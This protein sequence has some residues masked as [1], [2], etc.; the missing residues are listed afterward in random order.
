MR[1]K[2]V[3]F[4]SISMPQPGEREVKTPAE[5]EEKVLEAIPTP[6]KMKALSTIRAKMDTW[7]TN[8]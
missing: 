1:N 4:V 2:D 6:A 8:Q 7:D 3:N 5:I